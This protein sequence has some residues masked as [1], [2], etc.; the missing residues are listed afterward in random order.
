MKPFDG[1]IMID[2]KTAALW[3]APPPMHSEEIVT[4]VLGFELKVKIVVGDFETLGEHWTFENVD[5]GQVDPSSPH[6][7]NVKTGLTDSTACLVAAHESYHLFES[8]RHLITAN[9]EIAAET[10]GGLV[11]RIYELAITP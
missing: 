5:T 11:Q 10:F 3:Q 9:E 6:T 4:D 2:S 8:V 1:T 7:I